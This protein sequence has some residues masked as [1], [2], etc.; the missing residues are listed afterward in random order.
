M[1]EII[2]I[3]EFLD[4]VENR[5]TVP[6]EIWGY[7]PLTISLTIGLTIGLTFASCMVGTVP[8]I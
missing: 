3:R 2:E 5:G 7:I 1:P 8:A 4:A 6:L